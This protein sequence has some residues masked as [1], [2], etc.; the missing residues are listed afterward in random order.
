MAEATRADDDGLGAGAEDRDRLLDGV[1][2]GQAGVGQRGD[3]RRVQRRVELDHG[4]RRG[5]Q[6]LGEA[7]VTA[8]PREL[9]VDAVHVVALAAGTAE[10]AGDERVHDH[11]VA[12]LDVGHA[13]ADLVDPARVLVAGT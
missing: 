1:D 10:P 5:V 4:A 2:R 13:G 3:V 7:T 6:V 12:D 9:P 8:D 11:G